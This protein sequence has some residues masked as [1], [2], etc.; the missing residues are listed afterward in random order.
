MYVAD[1]MER[2]SVGIELNPDFCA[3][4]SENMEKL[5]KPTS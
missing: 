4:I 5:A 3:L 1:E 2:S